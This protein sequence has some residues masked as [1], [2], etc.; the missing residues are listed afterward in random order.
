M[1]K[2]S[3]ECKT[4]QTFII[5]SNLTQVTEDYTKVTDKSA[6]LLDVIMMSSSS[7]IESTG[8]L[9]TCIS[10]YLPVYAIVKLKVPKPQRSFK[11]IRSFKR[12]NPM[13]FKSDLYREHNTLDLILQPTDVNDKVSVFDKL[14]KS[15]LKKHA[16]LVTVK[17]KNRP[18]SFVTNEIKNV[19]RCRNHLHQIFLNTRRQA[20][21]IAFVTARNQVKA[22]LRHAEKDYYMS[23]VLKNK[24]N[25]GFLWN[26]I[27][28]C[29]SSRERNTLTYVKDLSLVAEEFNHYFT[30]VGSTI[31]LAAEKIAKDYNL[32]VFDPSRRTMLYPVDEQFHFEHVSTKEAQ[33][34]VLEMPLNK[35]LGIDFIPIRVLKDCLP[36]TLQ[37]L[38]NIINN[39]LMSATFPTNWKTS[40]TILLLELENVYDDTI[41]KA[42]MRYL[43]TNVRYHSWLWFLKY[44]KRSS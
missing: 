33:R 3:T 37:T 41:T 19:M 42:I 12:Y 13:E 6:S 9:G 22:A 2:D 43:V 38:T 18:C 39:S 7:L 40:M 11:T 17:I 29:I 8:V 4:F 31:A 26:I 15:T 36:I 23:E 5:E 14:L 20:D 44:V 30:S 34:I 25:S 10:D 28:I 32:L 21:W 1:N 35:S 27:N 16:P 24:N